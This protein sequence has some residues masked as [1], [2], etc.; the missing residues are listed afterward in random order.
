MV[1]GP[2]AKLA[3]VLG[4]TVT[5]H[6]M[7]GF[8]LTERCEP[9]CPRAG[10]RCTA[11]AQAFTCYMHSG[12]PNHTIHQRH[13]FLLSEVLITPSLR[14]SCWSVGWYTLRIGKLELACVP[15]KDIDTP[16]QSKAQARDRPA[17]R[18]GLWSVKQKTAH[19]L[20]ILPVS[21]LIFL[22]EVWGQ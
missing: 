1:C 11:T 3:K 21:M 9:A 2:Q 8:G 6:D 17:A 5:A 4:A 19:V 12:V 20:L 15:G 14:T 10:C 16:A 18:L 22:D 7:P 13:T